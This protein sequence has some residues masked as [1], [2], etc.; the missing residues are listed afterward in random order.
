L[1]HFP[2]EDKRMSAKSQSNTFRVKRFSFETEMS[3]NGLFSLKFWKL[4]EMALSRLLTAF[5]RTQQL[6]N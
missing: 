3:T 6:L 2:D 5:H 4:V 1:I